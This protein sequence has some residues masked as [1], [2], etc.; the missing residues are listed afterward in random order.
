MALSYLELLN[1]LLKTTLRSLVNKGEE[2]EQNF[3]EAFCSYAYFRIPIFRDC[4][5]AVIKKPSDP[6]SE[7]WKAFITSMSAEADKQILEHE[8]FY[9]VKFNW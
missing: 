1:T 5:L 4:I 9:S 6:D 8:S 2:N 3:V 7:E